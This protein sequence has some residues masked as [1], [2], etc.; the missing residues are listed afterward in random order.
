MSDPVILRIN[1]PYANEHEF[2]TEEVWTIDS[3]GAFLI[4]QAALE[5]NTLVRFDLVLASGELLI[6]AEGR[7]VKFVESSEARPAGLRVRFT[8]FYPYRHIRSNGCEEP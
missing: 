7:V 1:R 2:L 6:R 3:K 8:R 5:P 4:D